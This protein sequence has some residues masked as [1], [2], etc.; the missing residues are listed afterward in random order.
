MEKL[1]AEELQ[2][3]QDLQD[4]GQALINELGQ[5][6]IAKLSLE[7]R[8][9]KA[10]QTLANLQQEEVEYGKQMS[11][12]YGPITVNPETGEITKTEA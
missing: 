4:K 10:K 8:H 2:K 12:K 7:M 5:I 6:E 3:L 1:T 9:E 11:E